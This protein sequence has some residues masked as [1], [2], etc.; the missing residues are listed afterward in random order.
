[1]FMCLHECIPQYVFTFAYPGPFNSAL[2]TDLAL[3]QIAEHRSQLETLK[4]EESTILDGLR[5]FKIEQAPSKS[6][7]TLEKVWTSTRLRMLT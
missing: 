3:K 2:S 6:I 4:Q 5:F 1:M 7:R